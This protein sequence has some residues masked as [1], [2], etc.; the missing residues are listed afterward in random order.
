MF[1][2]CQCVPD[3]SDV[4]CGDDGCG[5]SCGDCPLGWVCADSEGAC[6][7][8]CIPDCREGCC[9]EDGCGGLCAERCAAIGLICDTDSCGCTGGGPCALLPE[10]VACDVLAPEPSTPEDVAAYYLDYAVP[11]YCDGEAF[12]QRDVTVFGLDAG[13]V[14][15]FMFGEVHGSHE[16]GRMSADI[17]ELLVRK[18][19]VNTLTMEIGVDMSAP[20]DE[21]VRTGG[22][23][24]GDAGWLERL[25][26][27]MFIRTLVERA[28]LLTYAGYPLFVFGADIPMLPSSA[29]GVVERLSDELSET[30]DHVLPLPA[31]S[32]WGGVDRNEAREW[33]DS[34]L[35]H[36][37]AICDEL[38]D[39]DDCE[40]F[41][42]YTNA[43]W[44][45]AVTSS[46][47]LQRLSPALQYEFFSRREEFIYF[48]YRTYLPDESFL[49]YSHMGAA[50][51]AKVE[52]ER[53]GFASAAARL[54]ADYPVTAGR[55]YSTTPAYGPNSRIRY[56]GEI[57]DLP[58]EPWALSRAL[59]SAPIT[60]YQVSTWRPSSDCVKRPHL[61]LRSSQDVLYS[62]AYDAFTWIRQLTPE[63]GGYMSEGGTFKS[64]SAF[65]PAPLILERRDAIAAARANLRR[66]L[67]AD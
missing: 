60:E 1:G 41:V 20:L 67:K 28:R 13:D 23:M 4:E 19:R 64:T 24:L 21:F 5:G 22:G 9:G 14:Q 49:T 62:E 35:D 50:H 57:Y 8:P 34:V 26:R 53:D 66:S 46:G 15:L 10:L 38:G 18:G 61:G 44:L 3:C 7:E 43:V 65:D 39:S 58:A 36:R 42:Q 32:R 33:R 48:V 11:L 6:H 47:A 45:S 40:W 37:D 2:R 16:L 56:G 52:S 30:R 51:T 29:V 59:E 17:F 27:G 25:P 54:D 12:K 31:V 63:S 55:I